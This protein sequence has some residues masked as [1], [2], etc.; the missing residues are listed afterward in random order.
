MRGAECSVR[1]L[2]AESDGVGLVSA[3]WPS[4]A[5]CRGAIGVARAQIPRSVQ[6]SDSPPSTQPCLEADT[7]AN[8]FIS[9]RGA[10]EADNR[11]S[12]SGPTSRSDLGFD[13]RFTAGHYSAFFAQL[14][15]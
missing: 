8:A 9:R 3:G 6:T 7:K 2:M 5:N 13:G 10:V 11:C 12:I 14:Q 1:W 15:R 4:H